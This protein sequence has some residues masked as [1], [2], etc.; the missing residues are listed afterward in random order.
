MWVYV[1][2]YYRRGIGSVPL[3][4]IQFFGRSYIVCCRLVSH[5]LANCVKNLLCFFVI[6]IWGGGVLIEYLKNKFK[7]FVTQNFVHL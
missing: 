6:K 2:L 7:V 5:K 3:I 4:L 1:L